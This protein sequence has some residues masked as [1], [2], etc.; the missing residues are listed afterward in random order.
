MPIQNPN[1]IVVFGGVGPVTV[2]DANNYLYVVYCGERPGRKFGTHVFRVTPNGTPEWVEYAPFTEGRVE[3]TIEPDG[4]Y[5]SFPTNKE[6]NIERVRIVGFVTPGY[7]TSGQSAPAP[8]PVPTQPTPTTPVPDMV[9]EGARAYTSDVKKLLLGEIGKL[10]QRVTNLEKRPVSGF[11]EQRV[12]DHAWA[13]AGERLY[14]EL[15]DPNSPISNLV[16]EL[17]TG[18]R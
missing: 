8:S 5:I 9:D 2:R 13:K 15:A 17:A 3:T 11:D 10:Q 7:P 16:R 1:G 14:A 6:R 18:K 4:L 12:N